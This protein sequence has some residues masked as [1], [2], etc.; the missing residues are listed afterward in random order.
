M[1]EKDVAQTSSGR[2]GVVGW[3]Q[4][5][6]LCVHSSTDVFLDLLYMRDYAWSRG[7]RRRK[8]KRRAPAMTRRTSP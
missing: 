3:G 8:N 4:G 5:S 7:L 1:R 6:W 2:S